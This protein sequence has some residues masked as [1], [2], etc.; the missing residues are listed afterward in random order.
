MLQRKNPTSN[1]GLKA[2]RRYVWFWGWLAFAVVSLAWPVAAYLQ[3]PEIRDL[4]EQHYLG[5][6]NRGYIGEP[7]WYY[8]GALPYILLPWSI[9]AFV[10][11]WLTRT[12]AWRGRYSP[13]R[14]CRWCGR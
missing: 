4:W 8:V 13:F 9:P 1:A 6:L 7:P 11:L 5:R 2:I 12:A 3:H 14:R 10:G